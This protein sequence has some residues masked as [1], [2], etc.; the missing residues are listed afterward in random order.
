VGNLYSREYF[1]LARRV[2]N[3]D[4]LMLQWVEW[5]TETQ[6][7]AQVRTFLSVF[8]NATLWQGGLLI[9]SK[10]PLQLN[11]LDFNRKLQDRATREA[12]GLIGI[13]SF[14][15]LLTMYRAGPEELQAHVGDGLVLTDDRPAMEYFLSLPDDGPGT[16]NTVGGDVMRHVAR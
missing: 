3:D 13:N 7:K 12:L 8:P 10:Q 9:G 6:Q 5:L 14:D 11:E 2:L 16:L 15:D 4:G 1:E